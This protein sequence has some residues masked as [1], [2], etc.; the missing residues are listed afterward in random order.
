MGT[1][2]P[3]YMTPKLNVVL[4]SDNRFRAGGLVS[5]C[6]PDDAAYYLAV[7]DRRLTGGRRMGHQ[8][9]Q[10]TAR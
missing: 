10:S 1:S 7:V 2:S 8:Q 3:I 9:T 6:G 5:Y 4:S